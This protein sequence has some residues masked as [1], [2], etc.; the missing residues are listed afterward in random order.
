M[1]SPVEYAAFGIAVA[2]ITTTIITKTFCFATEAKDAGEL[3][4]DLLSKVAH[5]HETL[6]VVDT[7]LRSRYPSNAIQK[8]ISTE[9][10]H[11]LEAIKGVLEH[12]QKTV[13]EFDELVKSLGDNS[14]RSGK[15]RW[16]RN[17]ILKLKLDAKSPV[18]TRLEGRLDAE[19]SSLKLMMTC[20]QTLVVDN[21]L[22]G[23]LAAIFRE[24]SSFKMELNRIVEHLETPEANSIS[25]R[26]L[27][28]SDDLE[29]NVEVFQLMSG[30]LEVA[31]VVTDKISNSGSVKEHYNGSSAATDEVPYVPGRSLPTSGASISRPVSPPNG[32]SPVTHSGKR[33]HCFPVEVQTSLIDAHKEQAKK[34]L[35]QRSYNLAEYNS[36]QA[37]LYAMERESVYNIPFEDRFDLDMILTEAYIGQRKFA[38]AEQ[39]LNSLKHL[40]RQNPLKIVQLHFSISELHRLEF[41]RNTNDSKLLDRWQKTAIEVYN[42]A[43][44]QSSIEPAC[45]NILQLSGQRL[46]EIFERKGDK[47]AATT[48]LQ[49]HPPT[50]DPSPTS[51]HLTPTITAGQQPAQSSSSIERSR[52]LSAVSTNPS[53]DISSGAVAGHDSLFDAIE[54]N[55]DRAVRA[56]L[57]A[58]HACTNELDNSGRTPLMYAA[59]KGHVKIVNM[60]LNRSPVREKDKNGKTVLHHALFAFNDESMIDSIMGF[61]VDINATDNEGSTP[62]H[63]C[64]TFNKLSAARLLIAHGA[65]LQIRDMANR[66]PAMLAKKK[67]DFEALFQRASTLVGTPDFQSANISTRVARLRG[68]SGGRKPSRTESVS[69]SNAP[70]RVFSEGS[71]GRRA[72]SVQTQETSASTL[73]TKTLRWK[74]SSRP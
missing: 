2:Q 18:I 48:F 72:S 55:N 57:L 58:N 32:L 63:T 31:S 46:H 60:L 73:F 68:R 16:W 19:M 1:A 53:S 13:D 65:D 23:S 41:Y 24:M 40:V 42:M 15:G 67:D 38:H 33:R 37:T 5:L 66:T 43:H 36:R 30:C 20:H 62:L 56:L 22:D 70:S 11:L 51:F 74:R 50:P 6:L 69:E 26:N 9:E 4:D 52:S 10:H 21:A 27:N 39:T 47:V 64:V 7:A 12:C 17:A 3:N 54:E 29:G 14:Q 59:L 44:E 49:L 35:K 8:P 45:I 28:D 25:I 61:D 71:K 34:D